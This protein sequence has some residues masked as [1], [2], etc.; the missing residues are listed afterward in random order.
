MGE[1]R[2]ADVLVE[3]VLEMVLEVTQSPV[4]NLRLV[5]V[6]MYIIVAVMST[7]KLMLE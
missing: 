1:Q 4:Q 6:H 2:A 3:A 7:L 5:A